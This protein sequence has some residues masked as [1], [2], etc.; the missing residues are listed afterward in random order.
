MY[1][2][3]VSNNFVFISIEGFNPFHSAASPAYSPSWLPFT[4]TLFSLIYSL[5]IISV[6]LSAT[7]TARNEGHLPQHIRHWA[8]VDDGSHWLLA[9]SGAS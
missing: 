5:L 6:P 4:V 1:D 8:D 7:D 9:M 2:I 3:L